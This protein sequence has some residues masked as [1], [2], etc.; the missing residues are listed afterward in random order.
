MSD[1]QSYQIISYQIII[2]SLSS[3]FSII[4]YDKSVYIISYHTWYIIFPPLWFT[5]LQIPTCTENML[6]VLPGIYVHVIVEILVISRG[7]RFCGG[8]LAVALPGQWLAG[9]VMEW[10][11]FGDNKFRWWLIRK[12]LMVVKVIWSLLVWR[13]EDSALKKV[14]GVT[15]SNFQHSYKMVRQ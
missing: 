13:N 8:G 5:M 10:M 3:Y 11:R 14:Y 2:I 6:F 1:F 7:L 15:C 12:N 9:L 4:W